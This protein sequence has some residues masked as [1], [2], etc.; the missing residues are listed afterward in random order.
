MD[1][2]TKEITKLK[3]YIARLENDLLGRGDEYDRCTVCNQ[4]F[5]IDWASVSTEDGLVCENC[6]THRSFPSAQEGA[7]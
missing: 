3:C 7:D 6:A 4:I 2:Q 5:P 1:K